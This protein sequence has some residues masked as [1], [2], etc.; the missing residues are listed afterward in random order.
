[1]TGDSVTSVAPFVMFAA[2]IAKGTRGPTFH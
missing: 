2:W 1:V